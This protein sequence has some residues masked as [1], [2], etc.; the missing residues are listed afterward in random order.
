MVKISVIVP[1]YNAVLYLEKC[2]NSLLMQTYKD[3]EII[4]VNDGS[5][6]NSL[7]ILEKYR[8]EDSRINIINIE[9]SGVG[10]ARNQGLQVFTG[11]YVSFIDADDWVNLTL[12]ETFVN[13]TFENP[14]D[15]WVFNLGY[16]YVKNSKIL[17]KNSVKL[18]DW[19]NWKSPETILTF[20]DC[21][22]P[23]YSGMSACN[24]IYRGDFLRNNNLKFAEGIIFED[25]LFNLQTMLKAKSL[26]VNPEIFY[27][28]N[29]ANTASVTKSYGNKIFDSL[30]VINEIE[31]TINEL[32][33]A[34]EYKY[35]LFQYKYEFLMSL[36]K[37]AKLPYLKLFHK[38]IAQCLNEVDIS[39]MDEEICKTLKN[40]EYYEKFQSMGWIYFYLYMKYPHLLFFKPHLFKG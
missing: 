31:S 1:V 19:D 36:Y 17:V 35:A 21:N 20:D 14:V 29:Q 33:L 22:N 10:A 18:E 26:K 34:D 12:Y 32:G 6:D 8:A 24:K 11:E 13:S 27:W 37:Q 7:E 25:A 23:F 39:S 40:Y 30:I 9:N 2:L 38:K 3:L 5:T 4:C 16:N 28:Y 15:I